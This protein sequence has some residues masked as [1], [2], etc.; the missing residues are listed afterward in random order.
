MDR[1]NKTP[2]TVLLLLAI[3]MAA[4]LSACSGSSNKTLIIVPTATATATTA[5]TQT[6][7][8]TPSTTPTPTA[9]ATIT[10]ALWVANGTNVVEFIPSPAH[11]W[12]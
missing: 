9:T 11:A 5:A 1:F 4:V 6:P 7:T 3:G 12:R 2:A 8:A 10:V